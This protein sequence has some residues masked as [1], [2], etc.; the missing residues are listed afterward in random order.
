MGGCYLGMAGH[1]VFNVKVTEIIHSNEHRIVLLALDISNFKYIN[2]FYGMDEGDKV[3]QDIADFYFVNEPLCLASHGIGFDQFRGAYK[4]DGMTHEDVVDYISRKNETFEEEL[5][6]R[7]PL[8]YQHVYVGLYFYDDPALDVR[9]AVDRANLAKKSTKGRFDIHCCIYSED[10]C[11][12]YLEHMDMSNEFVRACEEDRIEIFLQPKIS[13]SEGKAVGA[14]ALVRMR[15]R[16]GELIPPVRFVPVLE[17]TGMIGKL[18]DIMLD[19]TFVFQR[20]CIDKGIKPVPVS[21]NI[22]RQRFTSE[23]LLNYVVGLQKKY[24]IDSSL[25]ELEILETTFIDALDTMIN[26]INALREKGFRINVDDF[27][28][29]YSSLNQIANIPADI[30][31]FD[32]VFASRSLKNDKG[33]QVI[34]SLIEM[35]KMVNYDLVFEGI[36]T[37]EE[38][39]AVVSYGCDVIQGFYF[40]KPLSAKEFIKK[41]YMGGREATYGTQ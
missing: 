19:K 3:M 41:Y 20:E 22:S 29:G 1:D 12:E 23:G 14:E 2:D 26:V 16:D 18:D 10:N 24:D 30:I 21:V 4:V 40:D 32:R 37:K 35:L 5:S 17:H 13:V 28:S 38:L 15:N 7:Y 11:N 33:R 9:M 36:E 27:G 34:K 25:V 6:A 31:K 8:V 39:D